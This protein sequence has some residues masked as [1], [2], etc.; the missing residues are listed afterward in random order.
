MKL[1]VGKRWFQ[2]N[3]KEEPMVGI[4]PT[5]DALR[6]HCS[7]AEL[8]RLMAYPCDKLRHIS[9]VCDYKPKLSPLSSILS[10]PSL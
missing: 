3:E 8:H 7:T 6:K 5:T 1:I 2:Q 4:E 10:A 9:D